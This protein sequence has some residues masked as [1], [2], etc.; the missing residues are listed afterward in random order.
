MSLFRRI[1][2]VFTLTVVC[3]LVA[4]HAGLA[5]G[6][7]PKMVVFTSRAALMAHVS[8][9]YY[10]ENFD[11]LGG[12]N[13]Y[14]PVLSFSGN[15][16]TYDAF[17]PFGL[18]GIAVS[19]SDN[20]LSTFAASDSVRLTFTSG[21]VTAV[22]GEFFNTDINGGFVPGAIVV[23]LNDGTTQLVPR[24]YHNSLFRGFIARRGQF[25]TSLEVFGQTN[26]FFATVNNLIV[27]Q[28]KH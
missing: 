4:S 18:F 28:L 9:G 1:F 2:T 13:S 22:G 7:G 20:A 12:F 5:Q 6:D 17:A 11:S 24:N 26:I 23:T 14:G 15:G 3:A 25:I 8:P 10:E 27:G 21:N 19:G 16:F